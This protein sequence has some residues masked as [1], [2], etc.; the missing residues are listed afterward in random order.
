M[1]MGVIVMSMLDKAGVIFTEKKT[2]LTVQE[3]VV[4]EDMTQIHGVLHGGI[5]AAIAEQ[6]AS[7]GASLAMGEEKAALGLS[8]N[9]HHLKGVKVGEKCEAR[10][11]PERQGGSIQVWRVE[12]RTVADQ[13]LF[14]V[15]TVTIYGRD[16]K[17]V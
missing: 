1:R 2:T 12:Q 10:A 13:E 16:I 14:N 15:S 9:S 5:S 11:W 6:G 3:Y 8:I 7:L 4:T 17:I